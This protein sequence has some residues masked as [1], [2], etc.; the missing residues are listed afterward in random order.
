MRLRLVPYQQT[1]LANQWSQSKIKT[2]K[3]SKQYNI[4]FKY[5]QKGVNG[6]R[7]TFDSSL[8]VDS[9]VYKNGSTWI[10]I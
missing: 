1:F 4:L 10:R 5:L 6:R 7:D 9:I 2:F 3:S 8:I